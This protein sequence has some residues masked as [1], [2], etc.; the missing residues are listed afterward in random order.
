MQAT[1]CA[2]RGDTGFVELNAFLNKPAG[3]VVLA[4]GY[5]WGPPLQDGGRPQAR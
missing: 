2:C 1:C 3:H 4:V 5:P